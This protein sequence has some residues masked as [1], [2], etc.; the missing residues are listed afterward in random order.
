MNLNDMFSFEM[1]NNSFQSVD[2]DNEC[3]IINEGEETIK[4]QRCKFPFEHRGKVYHTCTYD[5][6]EIIKDKTAW[7]STEV[8]AKNSTDIGR[9]SSWGFC[10][11]NTCDTDLSKGNYC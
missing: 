9:L 10:D 6:S 8:Y 1:L 4:G 3:K 11:M 7:C 5:H 2:K